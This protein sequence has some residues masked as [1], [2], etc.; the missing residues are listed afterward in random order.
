MQ[1]WQPYLQATSLNL[2]I[3]WWTTRHIEIT[4]FTLFEVLNRKKGTSKLLEIFLW[5]FFFYLMTVVVIV[6]MNCSIPFLFHYL[7][8]TSYNTICFISFFLIDNID[9][10]FITMILLWSHM[11]INSILFLDISFAISWKSY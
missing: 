7:F 6:S 5:V 9:L 4:Y 2:H 11:A 8:L 10:Y 1:L 3:L